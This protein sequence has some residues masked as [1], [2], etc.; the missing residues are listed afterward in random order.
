MKLPDPEFWRGRRVLIT[1]HTGFKGGWLSAWLRQMGSNVTGYALPTE[2]TNGIYG[3]SVVPQSITSVRGDIRDITSIRECVRLMRPEIVFHLAAQSLVRRAHHDPAGTY[4]TN[5][6]GTQNVLDA[7]R[8]SP[9]ARAIVVV[10]SDKVYENRD[11][12]KPFTEDDRLGGVE[13]YG[14]SKAAAEMV[15][16]AFRHGL[17]ADSPIG[18]ATARAGNVIG[19]GDWAEDRLVP[20]AIK[21][22]SAGAPL[23]VRNPGATRP[24]QYVLDPLCGYLLLAERLFQGDRICRSAWNFGPDMS[25]SIPVADVA[26]KL[27]ESWNEN[28]DIPAS[29]QMVAQAGAPYEARFLGVNS[30]KAQTELGWHPRMPL[31]LAIAE[32]VGWYT[33]QRNGANMARLSAAMIAA[34]AL[35]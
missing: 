23:T 6:S 24:W 11:A 18:V 29:W 8:G 35:P 13:P 1:G 17:E 9:N 34:Y 22:F 2:Y 14:V 4:A 7:T 12:G 20:D 31:D 15:A 28:S 32:T 3:T 26:D 16:Q 33:A 5:V 30:T 25:D 19:G 21:A 27:V 10:T